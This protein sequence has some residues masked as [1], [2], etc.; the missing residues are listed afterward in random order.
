MSSNT[1]GSL[2]E[3]IRNLVHLEYAFLAKNDIRFIPDSC[4]ERISLQHLDVSQNCLQVLPKSMNGWRKPLITLNLDYNKLKELPHTLKDLVKVKDLFC[5]NN[6][7]SLISLNI[8]M[9]V[10]LRSLTL[11]HNLLENLPGNFSECRKLQLLEMDNNH[12]KLIPSGLSQLFKLSKFSTC[13]NGIC[14]THEIGSLISIVVI[15]FSSNNLQ[16]FPTEDLRL[17]KL[18]YL[19][20]SYNH[21]E[22]IPK[23][24]NA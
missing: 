19:N 8:G 20:L 17:S 5:S 4:S 3:G 11:N 18:V 9:M 6:S 15:N 12:F 14:Q 7:V 16:L 10:E 2:S 1:I 21:I 22:I 13:Y 24:K 23:D